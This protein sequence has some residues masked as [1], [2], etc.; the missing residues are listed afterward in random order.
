MIIQVE[1]KSIVSNHVSLFTTAYY[2]NSEKKPIEF[3][4]IY[5]MYMNHSNL[6]YSNIVHTDS[7]A[8]FGV[9]RLIWIKIRY[10][11]YFS[12]CQDAL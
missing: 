3:I 6:F 4:V 5:F 1:E 11:G 12:L 7:S 2:S 8:K 9:S 10:C